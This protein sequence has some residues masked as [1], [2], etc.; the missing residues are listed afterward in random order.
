MDGAPSLRQE[1]A[2]GPEGEHPA[3]KA[4]PEQASSVREGDSCNRQSEGAELPPRSCQHADAGAPEPHRERQ[5]IPSLVSQPCDQAEAPQQDPQVQRLQV[6]EGQDQE[7]A[8][9]EGQAIQEVR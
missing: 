4:Q 9:E 2:L 8:A 3:T 6:Q 1:E 5:A 7:H